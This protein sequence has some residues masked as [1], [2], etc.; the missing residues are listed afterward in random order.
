VSLGSGMQAAGAGY[1]H[2]CASLA[3]GG[4][5]CWGYN[6]YGNL[7]TGSSSSFTEATPV[8]VVGIDEVV[9]A[10]APAYYHTCA[11]TEAGGVK[12]WGYGYYFGQGSNIY[13]ATDITGL[14]SGVASLATTEEGTCAL[15]QNGEVRCLGANGNGQLGFGGGWTGTPTA[16]SLPGKAVSVAL[17]EEH[18]CAALENGDVYCW[19]QDY[20]GQVSGHYL[21]TPRLVLDIGP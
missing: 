12:C 8:A 6:T 14:T 4:V 7:G 17:H 5:R 15:M 2:A 20:R 21:L 9:T 10:L 11:L 16:L 19:G 3:A 13:T 18:G 1:D